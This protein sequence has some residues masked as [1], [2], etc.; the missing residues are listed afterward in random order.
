MGNGEH[1]PGGC[2][3]P[4]QALGQVDDEKGLEADLETDEGGRGESESPQVGLGDH[5][6][7]GCLDVGRRHPAP[8]LSVAVDLGAQ[9]LHD[10]G[11][12][13]EQGGGC[14]ERAAPP[15]VQDEERQHEAGQQ[16]ADGNAGLFD[17]KEQ[18]RMSRR[19]ITGQD[20]RTRWRREG[21]P[22]GD[23]HRGKGEQHER[24]RYRDGEAGCHYEKPGLAHAQ[25]AEALEEAT[26]HRDR[27][28]GRAIE[29]GGI[30]ADQRRIDIEFLGDDRGED[31]HHQ[32][33][34]VGE[35][36]VHEHGGGG[37]V[38]KL[39]PTHAILIGKAGVPT[40]APTSTNQAFPH[41]P[42][43]LSMTVARSG[44]VRITHWSRPS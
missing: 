17:G 12:C 31:G 26:A 18:R 40:A 43:L 24:A 11:E 41:V 36:L 4:T 10:D 33:N 38:E 37:D 29:D 1:V 13:Q 21:G 30:G 27:N 25:G 2:Q 9:R 19:T 32:R 8:G 23:H 39:Q 20:L 16:P 3:W 28:H 14:Q 22:D 44:T 35:A 42:S 6:L 15:D 5:R 34:Q 7:E